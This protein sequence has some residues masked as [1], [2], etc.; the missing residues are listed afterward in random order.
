MVLPAKPRT[1]LCPVCYAETGLLMRAS[2][3]TDGDKSQ[4]I[5]S[6]YNA[7]SKIIPNTE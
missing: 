1:D 7:L 3:L 4:V 5:I 2:N 6:T